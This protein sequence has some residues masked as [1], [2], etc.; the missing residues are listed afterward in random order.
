MGRLAAGPSLGCPPEFDPE[1]ESIE[2]VKVT[3]RKV[4]ISTKQH[5][6][7]EMLCRY[8]LVQRGGRWLLDRKEEHYASEGKWGNAIL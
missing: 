6:G 1:Q 7:F 8:T 4:V 2:M 5:T 3:P